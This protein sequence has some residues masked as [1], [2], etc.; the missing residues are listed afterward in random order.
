[1]TNK[2]LP[3]KDLIKM[4]NKDGDCLIWKGSVRCGR[5]HVILIPDAYPP[6]V[7][8]MI[9]QEFGL[10]NGKKADKLVMFCGN[11]L[12]INKDH[13]RFPG[14]LCDVLIDEDMNTDKLFPQVTA[15][16]VVKLALKRRPPLF[17]AWFSANSGER[18][19]A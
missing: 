13:F 19:A 15:D 17:T 1:M 9:I 10:G 18:M 7:K 16:E 8:K 14:Q 11:P 6:S 4:A 12:C 2:T 3:Y 5:P